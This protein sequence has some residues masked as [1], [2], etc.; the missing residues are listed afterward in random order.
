MNSFNINVFGN[1]NIG[2]LVSTNSDSPKQ[3]ELPQD[4]VHLGNQFP[5]LV[6]MPL[7]NMQLGQ[8]GNQFMNFN[9]S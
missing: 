8:P 2:Q 4:P 6:G 7:M 5:G 9:Q 3:D 1:L